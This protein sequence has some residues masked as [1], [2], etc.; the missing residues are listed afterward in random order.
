MTVW[1][2]PNSL[3]AHCI[4]LQTWLRS[5]RIATG[6][7]TKRWQY[8]ATLFKYKTRQPQPV[9]CRALQLHDRVCMPCQHPVG[10]MCLRMMAGGKGADEVGFIDHADAQICGW[11]SCAAVVVAA[12]QRAM[13]AGMAL[14]PKLQLIEYRCCTSLARV[15]KS[16]K[17]TS[18]AGK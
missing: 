10:G 3:A 16:P 15:Q 6:K 13:E 9:T 5:H 2:P 4:Q 1:K 7:F 14:P 8:R 18:C 12:Y 11:V 17:K